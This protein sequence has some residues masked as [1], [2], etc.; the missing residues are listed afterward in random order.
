MLF[1]SFLNALSIPME[2]ASRS[3]QEMSMTGIVI[4]LI[5]EML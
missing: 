1:H 2:L 3:G 4:V 5:G